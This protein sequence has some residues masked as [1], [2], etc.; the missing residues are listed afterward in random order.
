MRVNLPLRLV[1]ARKASNAAA[2]S[3]LVEDK[4]SMRSGHWLGL[5]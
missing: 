1:L 2:V 3:S 4:E 5:L